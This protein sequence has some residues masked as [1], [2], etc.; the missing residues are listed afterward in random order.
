MKWDIKLNRDL[1]REEAGNT[2][3]KFAT[4]TATGTQA[5]WAAHF[6]VVSW[7]TS[8]MLLWLASRTLVV[9][10]ETV[11]RG[12]WS[13]PC[14]DRTEVQRYVVCVC[15]RERE[16]EGERPHRE[17]NVREVRL[18]TGSCSNPESHFKTA[19]AQLFLTFPKSP[20]IKNDAY[21]GYLGLSVTLS[22]TFHSQVYTHYTLHACF[23]ICRPKPCHHKLS[24]LSSSLL[25]F[26]C[27][28]FHWRKQIH[29]GRTFISILSWI[30]CIKI[31]VSMQSNPT[32]NVQHFNRA[33]R[34]EQNLFQV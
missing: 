29:S 34:S 16:R 13:V 10:S 23:S 9:P 17:W 33:F 25:S 31:S 14:Q 7:Y 22:Y 4:R 26:T 8:S 21:D 32:L 30:V 24:T 1:T 28:D 20:G 19:C 11:D 5:S 12:R 15:E 27:K 2:Y 6:S 3:G 18:M